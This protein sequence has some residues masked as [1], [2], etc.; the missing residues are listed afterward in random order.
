MGNVRPCPSC[1]HPTPLDAAFCPACGAA[2][3]SQVLSD[4]L[5]GVSLSGSGSTTSYELAPQRLQAALGTSYELGRLIGR[6]GF[7]EVFAVRDVR[8]NRELALKVLRPDLILSATL[9]ERFRR[10]AEAVAAIQSTHIVPV[11][12]VGEADG[13]CWLLMPLVLGAT[14][15][16]VLL[17]EGRL[18]VEEV[19]RIL[20]E[21]AEGLQAAHDAGVVH[22]DIKPEN[23]MLDGKTGRVMLMDFGIAKAMDA[24]VDHALTG[25]G[26]VI[27][28][29]QYMSPEQAMGKHAPEPRSDQYSLAAVGYQMLTGRV[30][31]EGDNVREVMARQLLEE[32]TPLSRIVDGIPSAIS[33]TIHQALR[34]EPKQRFAS[35]AAFAKSLRGEVLSPEEGGIV[36]RKSEFNIPTRR[37]PW[38]AAMGWVL[39]AGAVGFGAKQAGWLTPTAPASAPAESLRVTPDSPRGRPSGGSRPARL[40]PVTAGTDTTTAPAPPAPPATC[41]EAFAAQAWTTAV[42]ACRSEADT[43]AASRRNLGLLYANGYGVEQNDRAAALQLG[44]AA[45]DFDT[46]AIMEMAR[47][48][49]TGKGVS[50][51]QAKAT[52]QYDLAA[53][54]GV[55]AAFPILGRRLE[56]GI[57]VKPDPK[58]AVA[59]YERAAEDGKGDLPSTTRLAAALAAGR[60]VKQDETRAQQLY[61]KA[62]ERRDSEAEYQMGMMLLNGKR[63]M[64]K[65]ERAAEGW[66]KRAA[67]QGHPQAVREVARRKW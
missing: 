49:D 15:K 35:M 2:A 23:L 57:G 1:S 8:L 19:R 41:A 7:A 50:V 40:A 39:L 67:A 60:G 17:R 6:G 20:L 58:K 54:L 31:F 30:P 36:R 65:D 63:G 10:E 56:E 52:G 48:Y 24:S 25:T 27:G 47:R 42:S 29:P 33:A 22:R 59:W 16:S 4:T 13:I 28:T 64:A 26:V 12:D 18:P 45:Q 44:F 51:D 62:A 14:L 3:A 66:L 55:K 32:P 53:N 21:A 38:L 9:V 46:V 37:R 5:V 61:S 34:K 43:S 11:Y